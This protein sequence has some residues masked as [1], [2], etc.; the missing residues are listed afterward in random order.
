MNSLFE[1][2]QFGGF[3]WASYLIAGLALGWIFIASWL[4]AKSLTNRLN[5]MM[6]DDTSDTKDK[7]KSISE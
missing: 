5:T 6:Q 7:D 4:R 3:I 2:G 1:M